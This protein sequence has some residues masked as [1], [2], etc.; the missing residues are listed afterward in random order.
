MNKIVIDGN[1][2]AGKTTQINM[3]QNLL[4][5]VKK[6]PIHLWPL[7][8]FYSN[9]ERWGFLF[10]MTILK[11]LIPD[12]KTCI[13]ERCPLS[14]LKVFWEILSKHSEEDK[15]YKA[16]Y[17]DYGWSPDVYIYIKTPPDICMERINS[18]T[19]DGDSGVSL[20][21]LRTLDSK[22]LEMYDGLDCKKYIID[23]TQSED[24]ILQNILS[25]INTWSVPY[26]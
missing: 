1:I 5:N 3:L 25:I 23:G 13:Y 7:E 15:L 24:I 17:R 22:Y 16:F 9:P 19:Q 18:R 2:G 8:L 12:T 26:V 11:T 10:Q 21:Y 20:D 4:Y 14:S 6:E